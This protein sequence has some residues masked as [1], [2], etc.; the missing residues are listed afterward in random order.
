MEVEVRRLDEKGV[1]GIASGLQTHR[2]DRLLDNA[3][4]DFD[5]HFRQVEGQV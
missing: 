3:F 1:E 2:I 4:R 5:E